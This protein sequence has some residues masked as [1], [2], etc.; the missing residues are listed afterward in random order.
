[1]TIRVHLPPALRHVMAGERTLDAEGAS[2]ASVLA[3]VGKK[4]P[5]LALHLFDEQGSV[6]H[7]IVC[8]HN[9]ELVRARQMDAH[10]VAPGDDL[11]LTNALAGG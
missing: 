3:D 4:H 1:V 10:A 2:V 6:R 5:S 9:G 8:V 7:N 11:I